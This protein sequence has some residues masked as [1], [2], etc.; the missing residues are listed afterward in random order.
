MRV[1]TICCLADTHGFHRKLEIPPADLLIFAGDISNRGEL[2][3]IADF[4]DWLGELSVPSI[5]I[6]GNHDL[7]LEKLD[8]H[9][10]ITNG[11]YLRDEST[12]IMGLT[13]YGSPMAKRIGRWAFG[14]DPDRAHLIWDNIP[15]NTDILVTHGPPSS[16]LDT[17]IY[18]E[19]LGCPELF[20]RVG[21]IKPRLH[22]VGH[23]HEARGTFYLGKTT[24]VNCAACN[25]PDYGDIRPPIVVGLRRD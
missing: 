4:N 1:T 12:E 14:Y 16:I 17:G 5:V 8:G 9:D 3:I 15:H 11:T 13:I 25:F 22:I 24:I 2:E 19:H 18:G 7:S 6:A 21:K 23:I 20:R 10:L